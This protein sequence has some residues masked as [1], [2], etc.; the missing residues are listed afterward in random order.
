MGMDFLD[1][2]MSVEEKFGIEFEEDDWAGISRDGDLSV[3]DLYES[4]LRKLHLRDVGRYDI[5]MNFELWTTMRDSL[6]RIANVP[7]ENIELGTNLKDLFPRKTRRRLWDELRE[8][9]PYRIRDLD[10]PLFVS[11]IGFGLSVT[12]VATEV[13]QIWQVPAL[14][15]LFPW[16]GFIGIWM[17]VETYAKMLKILSR[18]RT[19]FPKRMQTVKELCKHVLGANYELLCVDAHLPMD[20]RCIEV[21][22]DLTEILID[23]LGVKREEIAFDSRLVQDLGAS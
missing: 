7:L 2:T 16:G 11:W 10:Y 6:Q 22:Q 18:F 20:D 15:W 8:E 9:S 13:F 12:V 17:L 21:W 5:R 23:C 14:Q 1:I 19:R 3:G 4:I